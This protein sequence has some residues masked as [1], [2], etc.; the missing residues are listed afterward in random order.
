MDPGIKSYIYAGSAVFIWSTV[1][2]AFKL[3]L[4]H[5][6]PLHLLLVADITSVVLLG[7]ICLFTKRFQSLFAEMGIGEKGSSR[8]KPQN[9][10]WRN[11]NERKKRA[12]IYKS[13]LVQTTFLG[14]LNPFLYYCILF[15]AYNRLPA[16]VAQPLNYT[17]A[18][19]LA[20]LSVPL[21]G[22][23]LGKTELFSIL[24]SY[25]G[26]VVITTK[27]EFV[28]FAD[29]DPAGVCLALGST[30]F[31][32]LYWIGNARSRIDPVLSLFSQFVFAFPFILIASLIISGPLPGSLPGFLGGLYVGIFE[33]GITFVLWQNAMRLA[34][35]AAKV[36]ALI[37][38]SP[39]L[40]LVFIRFFLGE[41]ILPSTIWGLVLIVTGSAMQHLHTK[42]A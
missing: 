3:S 15:A 40:S 39:F 2:T 18:V 36:S 25:T 32:S 26:V 34:P 22:Q 35:S 6:A 12:K 33:M 1:A 29:L 17:W 23:K 16:Q 9:A 38:F 24:V 41:T 14:L 42:T 8:E 30:L 11:T 28:S 31:W 20:I 27:G 7:G 10:E 13:P 37:F 4:E 19:A 5:Y 21:L